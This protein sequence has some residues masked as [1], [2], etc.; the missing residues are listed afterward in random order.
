MPRVRLPGF[1]LIPKGRFAGRC[2]SPALHRNRPL[3]AMPSSLPASANPKRAEWADYCAGSSALAANSFGREL[4]E[5][6]NCGSLVFEH[7]EHGVEL[8]DLQQ[9]LHALAQ[10]QQLQ[11]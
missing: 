11:L 4:G 1:S 5:A 7:L 8:G 2:A 6:A 3:P 9:I 10:P